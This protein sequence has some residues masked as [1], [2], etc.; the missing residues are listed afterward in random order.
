MLRNRSGCPY[1]P[2]RIC[3][4]EIAN[5]CFMDGQL[6][7]AS[8]RHDRRP[9]GNE[10]TPRAFMRGDAGADREHEGKRRVKP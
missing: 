3:L 8:E 4:R 7:N 2:H 6:T 9:A 10:S 1:K 5:R